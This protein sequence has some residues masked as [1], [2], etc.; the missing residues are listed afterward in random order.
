[1]GRTVIV[2]GGGAS[3]LMA[4][5]AAARAGAEV[6]VLEGMERCG[7]KLLLTGNGRCN[8]TNLDPELPGKYY[9]TGATLAE[10]VIRGF[11]TFQTLSFFEEL[12][13]LTQEKNGYVYPYSAQAGAVL[14]VLLTE[15]R[16]LKVKLKF[17]EK[18]E[19][20]EKKNGEWQVKT[21]TWRYTAQ[22]LILACGSKAA[23]GTGSDGSGYTLANMLGHTVLPP[24]PALAPLVCRGNVFSQ[25]AGVRCRGTVSLFQKKGGQKLLLKQDTGELQWTKYGVSGIVVFQLSRFVS[26]NENDGGLY[27]EIDLLPDFDE[28]YLKALLHR[29]AARL[30]K[31]RTASV[32]S[33]FLHEKLIP[34]VLK[35]AGISVKAV[36][37]DLSDGQILKL[38]DVSKHFCL[39]VKETKSF[40][41]CQVCSGGVDC[42]EV[43]A[44][45]LQSL[46][47][48]GLF[49]AGEL[50]DVD[51][52][53][54]GYNLQWAWSSGYT[55]GSA[56][57]T[58]N[59]NFGK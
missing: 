17:G 2:A 20:A 47:H 32:L 5:I 26:E 46:K 28:D 23:P 51:G 38:A 9:G 45:S 53:C 14:E 10:Q 24:R 6:T 36:C 19:S 13:L 54:G 34:V 56:A 22:A 59:G 30:P 57:T 7:K 16:R 33:G 11:G 3:G 42:R 48:D 52:P 29:Q 25:L 41:V 58:E 39:E 18:I 37:G 40:D 35:A 50:L 12:G 31:E 27:L 21:A 15:L 4:A 55:A 43:S 44:E 8:L 1:M 49:F